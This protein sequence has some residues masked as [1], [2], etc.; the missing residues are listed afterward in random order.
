MVKRPSDWPSDGLID[1]RRHDPPHESSGTEWWYLNCHLGLADG[2]S[3]SL[4]A[5]FFRIVTGRDEE[6]KLPE[7]AHSLT[8]ALYDADSGKYLAESRVDRRA[9]ELGLQR[10]DKGEGTRDP[11]LRRAMR[12]VLAKGRVPYP[13]R[14]FDGEVFVSQ[15]RLELDY[16]GATLRRQDDGS[17]HLHLEHDYYN[18][19]CDLTFRPTK[20]PVR[21][22]DD[23]VVRGVSGDTMFYY[24]IPRCEVTGTVFTR[25]ADVEAT[26]QG[27]Y[28]HELGGRFEEGRGHED[29]AWSWLAVQLDDGREVTAYH[30]VD[31][32]T[33]ET[34]G[35]KAVLVGAGGEVSSWNDMTLA[36]SEP[37]RS[38]RTFNDYPTRWTLTVPSADLTL[39]LVAA[40]A[41]Q[42]FVTVLSKPAFWEGRCDAAGT[43]GG[44]EVRG[45]AWVERSGFS[46]V[47]TLDQFF[48]AV[49]EEVRKS[50]RALVPTE[51]TYEE[52]RNLVASPERD[53]YMRGV[54]I[55]QLKRTM[56][57]PVRTM[58][59]RGGKGWR[60][61]AALACCDVVGGDSRRYVQ[62]LAMPELMHTGS[63][64]VDDVQDRSTWR[65]GG[66]TCH[67]IFGEA[68]AINAGTA[69][70]FMGQ[71][72][73]TGSHV[74]DRD[75]LRL[76]DLYFE[77]LR[78]GHAGQ[79]LDIDG[80][81]WMM[82]SVVETGDGASLE[83]HV[84]AVHRLKTA[85]PAGALARM[86][87]VAGKGSEEQ[88]EG[89]GRYFEAVGLA[90]QI[91]DDVLNLRG[92]KGDLK[93]RGEDIS[94]GKITMPVAKGMV[95]LDADRRR[96]LWDEVSAKH[97][98]QGR[99]DAVIELLEECGAIEACV[100][101]SRDLIESAWQTLDPLIED[102]M[103]KLMLR[104]FGWYVLE[105]HY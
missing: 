61:Y 9:P 52:T 92:F 47:E 87:A 82:P 44:A 69:C 93:S 59:D 32:R 86:G 3:V 83:E 49:G 103:V 11:R 66:P 73:L 58:T 12:E 37:W 67:V 77:A 40:A 31:T 81:G 16:S 42:E 94:H 43:I 60:S 28:D 14:L 68:L 41:D 1:L 104:A 70:Y 29:V 48:S 30:M 74:S 76:Y 101:Q 100:T 55:E 88:I 38:T 105:R 56:M 6:T 26:G 34:V 35:R 17:Y 19:G 71:K 27:W 51:P 80:M 89:V 10:L 98:E 7:Y 91:M 62:W 46:S 72:L 96:W 65:R 95:A 79:A 39:E 78:A 50:V 18:V 64:I 97:E 5:A 63:L 84:L 90:F 25:G 15:E 2:R 57:R 85:A 53:H 36:P 33:G 8:W 54:D 22:G 75:K 23:G 4:F 102:S 20:G 13:D 99:I 21:H 45:L 24:F